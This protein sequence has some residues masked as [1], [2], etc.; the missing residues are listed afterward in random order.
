M[1]GTFG[2]LNKVGFY[3]IKAYKENAF[4]AKNAIKHAVWAFWFKCLFKES[5]R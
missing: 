3:K 4:R 2:I 5:R 1:D